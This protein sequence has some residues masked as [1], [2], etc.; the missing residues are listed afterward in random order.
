VNAPRKPATRIDE[1]GRRQV[2]P[3]WESLVERQLREAMEDGRFDDLPYQGERIPFEDDAYAGDRAM[4][5]HVLRSANVA[6]PW[7]EADKEVRT[8]LALRDGIVARAAARTGRSAHAERRDRTELEA[9]VVE[10]NAAIARLNAEAP[11]DRQH[12]RPLSL[13]GELA[14]LDAAVGVPAAHRG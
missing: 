9:L 10:I 4:A 1:H 6:P 3:T 5:F 11:T 13:A 2:A 14:R 12:R 7:I 8:L